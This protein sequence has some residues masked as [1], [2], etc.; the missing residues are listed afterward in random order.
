M[1]KTTKLPSPLEYWTQFVQKK[2]FPQE[3]L[4]FERTQQSSTCATTPALVR[5]FRLGFDQEKNVF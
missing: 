4:Q 3:Y 2:H 1:R 5:E